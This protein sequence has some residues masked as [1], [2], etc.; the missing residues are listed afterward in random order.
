MANSWRGLLELLLPTRCVMC[1]RLGSKVICTDCMAG[2]DPVGVHCSRCG[3]RRET[4]FA[5]PDCGECF[6]HSIGVQRARSAY[7]YNSTGRALLAEFKY[8]QRIGVGLVLLGGLLQSLQSSLVTWYSDPAA[9]CSIIIPVPLHNARLRTRRF[10]QAELIARRLAQQLHLPCQ[11]HALIRTR[12]TPSQVGLSA[13]QR[14]ENV[15]GAFA[16]PG[17]YSRL[18]AGQSVLLVDDLMTTGATLAACA[19]ALRK[20]G[21]TAV[22]GMTL[23]STHY[24]AVTD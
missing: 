21:A 24:S 10:N 8:H 20:G 5:S 14:Q 11:P 18:L 1:Q 9:A 19:R 2:L 3:R 17:N 6:G 12:E 16:V 15:R 23:F 7:I 22:Y 13:N 4:S